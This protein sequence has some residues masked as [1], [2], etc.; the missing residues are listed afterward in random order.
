MLFQD[1]PQHLLIL[2]I[3]PHHTILARGGVLI[4]VNKDIEP[5][6]PETG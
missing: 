3:M 4:L 5:P 1:I 6:A 2:G